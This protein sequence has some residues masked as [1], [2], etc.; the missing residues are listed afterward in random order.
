MNDTMKLWVTSSCEKYEETQEQSVED[1]VA[2][3]NLGVPST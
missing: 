1:T 3:Q 2:E